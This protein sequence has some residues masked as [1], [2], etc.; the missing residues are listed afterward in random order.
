MPAAKY[1]PYGIDDL[2]D[3]KVWSLQNPNALNLLKEI[4]YQWRGSNA[5]VKGKPGRWAVWPIQLRI[6]VQ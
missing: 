4:I 1:T 2:A 6:S 3:F 5:K